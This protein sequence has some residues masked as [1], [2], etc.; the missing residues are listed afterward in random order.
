VKKKTTKMRKMEEMGISDQ[1]FDNTFVHRTRLFLLT[2][3]RELG[4]SGSCNMIFGHQRNG[5]GWTL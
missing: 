4:R 5:W 1:E 3:C 2:I